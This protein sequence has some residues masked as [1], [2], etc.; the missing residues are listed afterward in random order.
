MKQKHRIHEELIIGWAKGREIQRLTAKGWVDTEH[1]TWYPQHK[2]RFKP[3]EINF[4]WE[5]FPKFN[6]VARDLSGRVYFY[7][8]EPSILPDRCEWSSGTTSAYTEM[9]PSMVIP[10]YEDLEWQD[11]LL[12][13]PQEKQDD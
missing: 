10:F 7:V 13:R 9:P 6:Y 8:K 4:P 11:S 5:Y 1:P 2:Y 3:R 12:C